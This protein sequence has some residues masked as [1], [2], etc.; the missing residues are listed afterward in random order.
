MELLTELLNTPYEFLKNYGGPF[1]LI[2]SILVFLLVLGHYIVARWCGVKV[3]KFSI[4]FGPE[5]FWSYR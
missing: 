2:L 4:G 5:L 3:E 1:I